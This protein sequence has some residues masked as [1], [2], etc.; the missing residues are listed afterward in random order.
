ML[1]SRQA[2]EEMRKLAIILT[3]VFV[4]ARPAY[5]VTIFDH[6]IYKKVFLKANHMVILANRITGEVKFIRLNNGRWEP[7]TGGLK[8]KCQLI[9]DNQSSSK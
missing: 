7:L 1:S 6:L 5:A 2:E 9:Y 3:L 4:L 8:N